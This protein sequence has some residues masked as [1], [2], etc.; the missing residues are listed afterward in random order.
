MNQA[1]NATYAE[2]DQQLCIIHQIR[3]STKY[4]AEKD[5]KAV[6][7]SLKTIYGAVNLENAEYAKEAVRETWGR[8]YP[9]LLRCW[10]DNWADLVTFFQFTPEIR[11]LIY[12]TNAVEGFHR[13][14]RKFTKT[15]TIFPTDDAV[16]KAV[17]LSV[18][19][20]FKKWTMPVRNW[21]MIYGQLLLHFGGRFLH[22]S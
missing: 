5:R 2:C 17:F 7:A 3:S 4:V 9:S 16:K 1:I 15:R 18:R 20:I 12:T 10:D 14:L 21:G 19:E 11:S 8:K 6:C 22:A 13:M